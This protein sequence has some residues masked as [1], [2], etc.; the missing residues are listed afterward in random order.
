MAGS[1]PTLGPPKTDAGRRNLAVP[2][3]VLPI[4]SEHLVQ[5]VGPDSEA[6]LFPG[7]EGQPAHPRSLDH[8]WAKARQVVSREDLRFHDVRHSGLT[9]AAATGASTA[10]LMRRGGHASPQAALRY[11]HATED[12]D[13]I[14]AD[15]LADLA[16][17]AP[18][19]PIEVPAENLAEFPRT[20]VRSGQ[21]RQS[22]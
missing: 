2:S 20:S 8:A 6:W 14:L 13:R 15:A 21:H 9:L 12:R 19:V 16:K 3:N 4:L 7:Q 22:A 17:R 5:H 10:E 11:Q 18:V 1:R